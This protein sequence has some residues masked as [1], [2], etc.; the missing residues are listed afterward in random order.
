MTHEEIKI[1][2]SAYFDG[3]VT[4]SEQNIVEE[5]LNTCVSCQKDYKMYK[6]T[7]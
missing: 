4:P 2:I 1:L 5:H 7:G 6:S 3:E